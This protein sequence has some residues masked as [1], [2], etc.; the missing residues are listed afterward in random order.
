MPM[1]IPLPTKAKITALVCTGRTRPKVMNWR[2]RLAAG[3]NICVATSRPAAM[4]TMPQ[5]TVAMANARTIWLSYLNVSTCAPEPPPVF[6]RPLDL[7]GRNASLIS[8]SCN[9]LVPSWLPRPAAGF[10][11]FWKPRFAGFILAQ[12]AHRGRAGV[13][14]LPVFFSPKESPEKGQCDG[15]ACKDQ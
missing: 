2:F 3:Q 4:P 5:T 13:L 12:D 11:A 14:E 1:N 8:D 15:Q 7:S 9:A 10:P 6:C